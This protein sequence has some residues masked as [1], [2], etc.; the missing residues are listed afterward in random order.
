MWSKLYHHGVDYQ[1]SY[2]PHKTKIT[3]KGDKIYLNPEIEEI[4]TILCKNNYHIFLKTDKVFHHNFRTSLK[5]MNF[6][7]DLLL[8]DFD[9]YRLQIIEKDIK[10]NQIFKGTSN[11]MYKDNKKIKINNRVEPTTIFMGRGKHPL[12]GS[13]KRKIE[14]KD[15]IINISRDNKLSTEWKD[16]VEKKECNWIAQWKDPVTKK[17]KYIHIIK[18]SNNFK[19]FD[20]AI[21]FGK[22]LKTFRNKYVND[23]YNCK[24]S[25]KDVI[26]CV[27][28]IDKFLL[29][30]GN[31]PEYSD[32]CGCCTL[33]KNNFILNNQNLTI[34]FVGKDSI[35]YSR[36]LKITEPFNS[37][38]KNKLNSVSN[39]DY[40]FNTNP[41]IVNRYLNRLYPGLTAKV[42]RT[43]H[44]NRIITAEL[45]KTNTAIGPKQKLSNALKKV[46]IACNHKILRNNKYMFST[47]T[48]KKNYIDPR[49]IN[50]YCSKNNV[51]YFIDDE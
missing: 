50:D 23:F 26:V 38:V 20:F 49:I 8:F 18:N 32:T 3:Y 31:E 34:N 16:I 7:H 11:S 12:R 37:Y 35:P 27:Y 1:I 39:N 42:F 24:D 44:A 19:K 10:C 4:F 2:I 22:R 46:A 33:K 6:T 51:E 17:I 40:V 41:H 43:C 5:K 9:N 13:I 48:S 45:N 25:I 30:V 15:I 28:L 14:P 21:N 36:T 29:R 47:T